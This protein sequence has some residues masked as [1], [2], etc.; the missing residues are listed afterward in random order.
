MFWIR[1]S[2]PFLRIGV[3]DLHHGGGTFC[4][5]SGQT[6]QV[7]D[8]GIAGKHMGS[9]VL[10]AQN[11]PLGEH[12]QAVKGNRSG[13]AGGGIR[14]N[15]VEEGHIDAVVVPVKGHRLDGGPLR[16]ENFRRRFRQFRHRSHRHHLQS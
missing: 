13:A 1:V 8:A 16:L 7:T 6:V 15:P 9:T 14:Q 4:G 3:R 11:H 5:V 2:F 12:R 10:T